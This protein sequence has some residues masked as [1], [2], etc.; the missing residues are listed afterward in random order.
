VSRVIFAY[1]KIYVW[2]AWLA[3]FLF[4]NYNHHNQALNKEGAN[5]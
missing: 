4:V 3:H 1:F 5:L 2:A